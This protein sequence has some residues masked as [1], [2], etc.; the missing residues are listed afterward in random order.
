MKKM[1]SLV[2]ITLMLS[3]CG[4]HEFQAGDPLIELEQSRQATEAACWN[5]QKQT[6][7]P[8]NMSDIAVAMIEQQKAFT[9]IIG[10]VTGKQ[11]GPCGGG[12]NLNDVLIADVKSRN[13][14]L[15]KIG[16]GAVEAVKLVGGIAAAGA[17]LSDITANA[18]N[19]SYSSSK[20]VSI[21]NAGDGIVNFTGDTTTT[22]TS[23][24]QEIYATDDAQ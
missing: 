13:E 15:Q 4:M 22:T 7:Y 14:S 3:G 21:E 24:N 5:A 6:V 17:A 1:I 18:G 12:T 9:Q 8:A 20:D 23:W 10:A 19:S 16:G 2:L 11:V